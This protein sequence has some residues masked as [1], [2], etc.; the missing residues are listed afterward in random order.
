[1]TDDEG[2]NERI[3]AAFDLAYPDSPVR[4]GP[5]HISRLRQGFMMAGLAISLSSVPT[6]EQTGHC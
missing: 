5:V 1:M 2:I 4:M 3:V 6:V